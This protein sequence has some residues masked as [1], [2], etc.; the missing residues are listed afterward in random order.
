[1]I[2][3]AHFSFENSGTAK[4]HGYFTCIVDAENFQA[5]L[6][7]IRRLLKDLEHRHHL[8]EAPASIFLDDLIEVRKIPS[9]GLLAHMITREG[10]LKNAESRS[11]PG[12]DASFCQSFSVEAS[13]EDGQTAEISPFLTLQSE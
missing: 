12:V 8:F 7:E 6:E 3:F 2:Y 4:K 11:L 13:E 10:P 5:A 9:E 1:M